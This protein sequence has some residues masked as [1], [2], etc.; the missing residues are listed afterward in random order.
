MRRFLWTERDQVERYIEMGVDVFG[1]AEDLGA[2]DRSVLGP[3]MFRKWIAPA[4]RRLIEP[5]QAA[6][7]QAH[8]HSDGYVMD[9]IDQ[10]L[11][12]GMTI[13]NI[14]D[15]V[16]GVENIRDTLKGRVCVDLDVDRQSIVPHGTPEEIAEL[17][18]HEVRALG[19]PQGGLMITCGVYP[20]TPPQNIDAVLTAMEKYQRYWWD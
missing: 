7:V 4:Y 6:G 3:R 11:E 2:Q 8:S 18:E 15:L 12:V 16:N 13:C 9:I 10:L 17:I 14:Q 1:L 5:L 19:S 20:P